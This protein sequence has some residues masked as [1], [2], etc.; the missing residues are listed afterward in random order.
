MGSCMGSQW[1]RQGVVAMR[2]EKETW[3]DINWTEKKM[4]GLNEGDEEI[5]IE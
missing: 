2:I 3:F 1:Y 5:V 4:R